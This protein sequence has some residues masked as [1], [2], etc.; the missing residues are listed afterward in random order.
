MTLEKKPI[1]LK[2]G[3]RSGAG[4][5]KGRNAYGEPTQPIRIPLSLLDP[6]DKLLQDFSRLRSSKELDALA[7]LTVGKRLRMPLYSSNVPAGFASPADDFVEEYLDLNDLLVK[8]EEATFFVRVSGRSMTD[9]GIQPDDILIVD[10]SLE[11][12]H[13]KIVIAVL[14]GEVTVKRLYNRGGKVILKAENSEYKDIEVDGD[15]HI[16]GVVTSVIHQV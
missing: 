4:R 7:P 13:G 15:L 12:E 5:P 10:R 3:A 2:G 14:N 6:V 11:A 16:W 8:R 9:A 1:P